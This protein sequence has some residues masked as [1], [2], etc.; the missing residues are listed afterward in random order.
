[1]GVKKIRLNSVFPSF[2][3][4][5]RE[6]SIEILVLDLQ[7]C[8]HL[9][10]LHNRKRIEYFRIPSRCSL[11]LL[12]TC[13][14]KAV[15][16]A[17]T[18]FPTLSLI[19]Q[20]CCPKSRERQVVR[21]HAKYISIFLIL[22]HWGIWNI[23]RLFEASK[24]AL[25]MNT[26]IFRQT[27]ESKDYTLMTRR[28]KFKLSQRLHD[29]ISLFTRF[30]PKVAYE[31][32]EIGDSSFTIHQQLLD[33]LSGSRKIFAECLTRE[34]HVDLKTKQPAALISEVN[35]R[36]SDLYRKTSAIWHTKNIFPD[37]V[38]KNPSYT[39]SICVPYSDMDFMQHMSQASYCKYYT[40][41]ATNAIDAGVFRHFE[42][43]IC[44]YP[45]LEV[46]IEYRGGLVAG[47]TIEV[48]TWQ[49]DENLQHLFFETRLKGNVINKALFVMGLEKSKKNRHSKI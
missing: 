1:M 40:D 42:H 14:T 45:I 15:R 20:V 35:H 22:G 25:T 26:D 3:G 43:D 5:A 38:K 17:V 6:D 18:E 24:Y 27:L 23:M 29:N 39:M 32:V 2:V 9:V 44:W 7:V 37:D 48:Q 47:E 10:F 21:S 12:R 4:K 36:Y 16:C 41:C 46:D 19:E 31:L 33:N 30:L 11:S 13:Q 34:V 49:D 8:C 28:Q